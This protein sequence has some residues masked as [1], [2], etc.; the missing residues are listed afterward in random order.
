[1]QLMPATASELVERRGQRLHDLDALYDPAVSL[2]LGAE[3]LAAQLR[4]FEGRPDRIELAAAAYNAGPGRVAAWQRGTVR[5]PAE[6]R[7]YRELVRRLW[8]ERDAPRSAT[9]AARG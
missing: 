4:R 6:T 5:L 9:L 3:Y 8:R 7:R 1:M 2:D